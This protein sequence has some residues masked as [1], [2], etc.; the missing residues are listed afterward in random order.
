MIEHQRSVKLFWI[1]G[2]GDEQDSMNEKSW[3]AERDLPAMRS[4]IPSGNN[5]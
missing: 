2:K 1:L 5:Y 3:E 4:A